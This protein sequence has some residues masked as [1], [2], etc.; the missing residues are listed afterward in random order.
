MLTA[1]NLSLSYQDGPIR[2]PIFSN[3][4]LTINPGEFVAILGP[5]GSGKSSLLYVLSTL[6]KSDSGLI[7]L[8]DVIISNTKRSWKI[9]YSNFGFIFQQ[10]F[11]IPHLNVL[12]NVMVADYRGKLRNEAADLLDRLGL[13]THIY[14]RPYEL[15]GGERQRVA[16]A[17]A[18]IKKPKVLFADEPTASLDPKTASETMSLLISHCKETAIICTTHDMS[19]LPKNC[20]VAHLTDGSLRF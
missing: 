17:R 11:L 5:S 20:R 3:I 7:S 16:I 4:S 12:E 9:R 2:R 1:E 19:I 6:R 10:H 18:L 15:S 8:D 13:S 14:K